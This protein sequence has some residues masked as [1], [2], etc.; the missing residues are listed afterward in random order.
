MKI[1]LAVLQEQ[2]RMANSTKFVK[3]KPKTPMKMITG[4]MNFPTAVQD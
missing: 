3:T 2:K 1:V 4:K